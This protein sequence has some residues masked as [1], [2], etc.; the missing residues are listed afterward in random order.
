MSIGMHVPEFYFDKSVKGIKQI[1][2]AYNMP[3]INP[4]PGEPRLLRH[5][6]AAQ[7]NRPDFFTTKNNT[8]TA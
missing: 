2:Y 8:I 7:Q 3:P 4:S 5:K 1:N 6:Q